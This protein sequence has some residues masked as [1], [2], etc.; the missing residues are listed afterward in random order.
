MSAGEMQLR[1]GSID[2]SQHGA[3]FVLTGTSSGAA[4]TL[5][6]ATSS[7]G[8]FDIITI[9]ARV[10]GAPGLDPVVTLMLPETGGGYVE[11]KVS[12]R[13]LGGP[14]VI[15]DSSPYNGGLSIKA[16]TDTASMVSLKVDVSRYQES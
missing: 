13:E 15:L 1:F 3:D 10:V 14:R 9:E 11:M 16:Y 12:L 7:A 2:T 5:H 6:T 4:H 8:F